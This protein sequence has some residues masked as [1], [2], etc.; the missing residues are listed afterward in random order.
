MMPALLCRM[1]SGGVQVTNDNRVANDNR[2]QSTHVSAPVSV[3]QTL[4]TIQQM[5]PAAAAAAARATGAAV[6]QAAT[7]AATRVEASP[8][9]P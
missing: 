4:T 9:T 8:A 2:D 5:A 3:H 6:G 7:A 1:V